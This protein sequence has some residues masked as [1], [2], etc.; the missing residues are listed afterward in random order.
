MKKSVHSIALHFF[1]VTA[2]LAA[3][4]NTYRDTY[5]KQM[6]EIVLTHGAN[7]IKLNQSYENSLNDLK[8]QA[9]KGESEDSHRSPI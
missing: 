4:I 6:E 2:L 8:T 7:I 1:C 3:D 5:D 9:T